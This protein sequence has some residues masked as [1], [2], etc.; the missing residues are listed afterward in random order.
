MR[1][2]RESVSGTMSAGPN[3]A[4]EDLTAGFWQ[5][6]TRGG[7]PATQNAELGE[8]LTWHDADSI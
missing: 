3:S 5:D 4:D 1:S 6:G 2:V 7:H 8:L